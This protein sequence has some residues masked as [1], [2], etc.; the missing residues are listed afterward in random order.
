[1]ERLFIEKM[2][3]ILVNWEKLRIGY[4]WKFSAREN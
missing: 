1:M 2:R 3:K 4:E